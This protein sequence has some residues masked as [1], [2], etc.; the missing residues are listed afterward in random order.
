MIAKKDDNMTQHYYNTKANETH[1]FVLM[2]PY[3]ITKDLEGSQHSK[4][5]FIEYKEG[6]YQYGYTYHMPTMTGQLLVLQ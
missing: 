1:N 6:T 3:N 2:N 4:I 5:S